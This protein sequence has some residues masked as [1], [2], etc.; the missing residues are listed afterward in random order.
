VTHT[1]GLCGPF[2]LK[3]VS[4]KRQAA[5]PSCWIERSTKLFY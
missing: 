5:N 2:A 3:T 1:P 4:Q